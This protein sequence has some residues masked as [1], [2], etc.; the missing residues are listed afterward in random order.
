MLR[1]ASLV[2]WL[3][4]A[5]VVPDTATV[6]AQPQ[7]LMIGVTTP[8]SGP[9]A[10]FGLGL[11]H[12]A[13]LAVDRANAAGGMDGRPLQLVSLDDAGL[14]ERAAANA[15][16]LIKR[17]A[18]VIAGVHGARSAAAVAEVLGQG[19]GAAALVA[20]V[21]GTESLRDP[22]R[23]GV[24]HLRAGV[25]QESSAAVLHLDTLGVTRF[26][27]VTQS[28][29]LGDAGRERIEFELMRIA[30]RPAVSVNLEAEATPDVIQASMSKVCASR[31]EAVILAV[32]AVLARAAVAAARVQ[33][34]AVH[35]FVFSEAGAA[36]AA[37]QARSG[38]A[39]H[40]MAGLLVTQVVPH[41]GNA[42]HPMVSEYQ[43]ARSAQGAA[44]GG[45]P[46]MEGYLSVRVIQEALRP[47]GREA[48]RACL[49]QSLRSRRFE[50]PGLTVEFGQTQQ[51]ARPYVE[52]T[53]LDGEGRF[54]R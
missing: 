22:P 33:P 26:A 1:L 46:S 6:H 7:P 10:S 16:E 29:P 27:L 2:V 15:A 5:L 13:Q 24:F 53:L 4:G 31:P 50:L 21:T 23:P 3:A 44:P 43:R 30:M 39:R 19:S 38:A 32:D 52:I 9:N 35:Y 28:D 54:R 18:V 17:G 45:Y 25:A 12:G 42:M 11:L 37:P 40:P 34:C 20:P 14:P 48:S 8:Q 49:I 47:C 41:P 51:Q 36:L